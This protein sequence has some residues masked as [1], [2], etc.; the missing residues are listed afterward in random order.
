MLN[1]CLFTG[2]PSSS[3]SNPSLIITCIITLLRS[4]RCS[5]FF[6]FP[7]PRHRV[8]PASSMHASDTCIHRVTVATLSAG[9]ASPPGPD[10][11][12]YNPPSTPPVCRVQSL[13]NPT[14]TPPFPSTPTPYQAKQITQ[15]HKR[16]DEDVRC[17]SASFLQTH[18]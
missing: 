11:V 17:I 3:P 12:H 1:V 13:E 6:H 8:V 14:S 9:V 16:R 5:F 10:I 2:H 18:R 4:S 7:S 15:N